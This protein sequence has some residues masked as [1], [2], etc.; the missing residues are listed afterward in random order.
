MLGERTDLIYGQAGWKQ[1]SAADFDGWA[2][3]LGGWELVKETDKVKIREAWTSWLR[4]GASGTVND[5]VDGGHPLAD[6]RY[7][8]VGA[9]QLAQRAA[10]TASEI[11][12]VVARGE[13]SKQAFFLLSSRAYH[14][15]PSDYALTAPGEYFAECYAHYYREYDGTPATADKKGASLAPWIKTWFDERVDTI[16]H[17]PQRNGNKGQ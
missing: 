4:G 8:K 13:Y 2:T 12:G 10:G 16:G 7:Q 9:V 6:A 15:T 11:N 3:A 14:S 5:M 1:F 17:N